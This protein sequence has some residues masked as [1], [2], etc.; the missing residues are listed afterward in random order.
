MKL[1]R[2]ERRQRQM[3]ISD[4]LVDLEA[5]QGV[6]WPPATGLLDAVAWLAEGSRGGGTGGGRAGG[7]AAPAWLEAAPLAAACAVEK[8]LNIP[9]LRTGVAD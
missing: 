1:H 6:R 3:I 2:V 7:A 8:G 9:M 5:V 4:S